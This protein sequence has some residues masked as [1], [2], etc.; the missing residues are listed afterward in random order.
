LKK[1]KAFQVGNGKKMSQRDPNRVGEITAVIRQRSWSGGLSKRGVKP[2]E[3]AQPNGAQ[4]NSRDQGGIRAKGK[5]G[6]K[7]FRNTIRGKVG[8]IKGPGASKIVFYKW[9]RHSKLR[10]K[11][12]LY[13][14]WEDNCGKKA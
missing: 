4:E 10:K 5:G 2:K 6:R 8:K 12:N 13:P 14:R 3:T 11:G 1:K 9:E 7:R